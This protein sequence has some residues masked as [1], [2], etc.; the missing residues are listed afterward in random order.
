MTNSVWIALGLV[1]IIEGAG[2]LIAPK[3]WRNMMSQLAQQPD[4]MLRRL[5]GCLVV[6]GIVIG[7]T[8]FHL[9]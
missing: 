1:L 3:A 9:L 4:N 2:P 5:G 7:Y 8:M 6:T